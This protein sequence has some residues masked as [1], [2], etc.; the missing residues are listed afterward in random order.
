MSELPE[1]A[2]LPCEL[3]VPELLP[4]EVP[5]PELPL[6]DDPA[7]PELEPALCAAAPPAIASAPAATIAPMPFT[8]TFLLSAP[9]MAR[10]D[11]GRGPS[12]TDSRGR[13]PAR[14]AKERASS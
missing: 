9:R 8:M 10:T 3:P 4:C 13:K 5:E 2:L 14:A 7:V 1:P 6:C 12:P 11:T